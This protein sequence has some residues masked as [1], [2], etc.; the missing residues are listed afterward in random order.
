MISFISC[1][2]DRLGGMG[3]YFTFPSFS[4]AKKQR[5]GV[6]FELHPAENKKKNL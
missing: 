2:T 1:K 3:E 5:F 6:G 4:F